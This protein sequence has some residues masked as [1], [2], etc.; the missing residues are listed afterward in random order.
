MHQYKS[1]RRRL[2]HQASEAVER[3]RHLK[4]AQRLYLNLRTVL[5]KQPGPGIKEQLLKTQRALKIRGD[6]LKVESHFLFRYLRQLCN[7]L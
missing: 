4:E 7:I 6:K 2:L 5:A 1:Y 3:E